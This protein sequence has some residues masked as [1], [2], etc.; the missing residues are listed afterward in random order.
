MRV[1][2]SKNL[3]QAVAALLA[4][5]GLLAYTPALAQTQPEPYRNVDEFGVDVSTGTFN[6]I[7][8]ALSAGGIDYRRFWTRAGWNDQWGGTLTDELVSGVR[9]A[10]I[11]R[12]GISDIFKLVSG[13]WVSQKG[14]GG[15]LTRTT[16]M[17]GQYDYQYRDAGGNQIHFVSLGRQAVAPDD[18]PPEFF[19]TAGDRG[20]C[21]AGERPFS[22][23]A[24]PLVCAVPDAMEMADGSHYSLWWDYE[25]THCNLVSPPGTYS[26]NLDYRLRQVRANN[27][28]SIGYAYESATAGT[29]AWFRKTKV[30]LA[31]RAAAYC[32]E[33]DSCTASGP[34]NIYSQPASNTQQ[35][36]DQNGGTWLFT[37]DINRRITSIQKPGDSTAST[38]ITYNASGKVASVTKDGVAKT[39]TWSTSSGNEVLAISG[40]ASGGATVTTDPSQEQ[41]A[42]IVNAASNTTSNTY[43]ASNRLTRTTEP[44]GNYF[45]YTY[46]ARG[47]NAETRLVA[48]SASGLADIVTTAN[49]DAAC[50]NPLKCNKPNYVIDPLGNRTDYTYSATH[51]QVTRVQLPSP[52]ADAPGTETGTRP[53]IHYSHTALYAKEKN[54][55][56]TLVNVATPEYKPTTI[57]TCA[58][59]ATCA[60]TANETKVTIEYNTPNLLPTK[61][62]TASGNGA[63]SSSVAYTYDARNNL[64]SVDG[65]LAGTDDTTSYIYDAN[66]RRRGVIGPDPDGAGS[67]PRGAE[68]YTFDT[69]SRVIKAEVGTVTAATEAALNAMTVIQTLD[70]T[71]D[72]AGNKTKDVLSGTSGAVSVVQYSY[73][74]LNRLECT[75]LRMNSATWASLPASACTPATASTTYGPDRISRNSYDS[76]GRVSKVE[77]AVGAAVASDEVRTAFTANG[78]VDYVIDAETNRTTY[79]YDGFDR[80]SQTRYPVT[81]KGAN[82]SNASDYEGLTYDARSSVT[83]RRLRDGTS[84]AYSY[85]DLG[86]LTTKDLPGSEPNTTY[87]YDLMGGPTSIDKAGF[88]ISF[89]QDALGRLMSQ[90]GPLGT[91]GYTYDAA[92]RRLTM[93]Y[94]GGTLTINYDYDVVGNV[95][96]IREN[97]ATSGVGV[98]AAYAYDNVGRRSSVTFGN[99]SV[100]SFG[101]DASQRLQTLTNDL[102]GA[103]TTHDLTQIFTYNPASQIA[104]VARSNDAYAWQAH[105][106]LDRAYVADG[107]NRIMSA[108]GTAYT[109]DARGNLSISG[110]S[111]SSENLLT[112]VNGVSGMAY[113]PLGRLFHM[114]STSGWTRFGYDGADMILETDHLSNIRRY[115]HGPGLD[116]PIVWYEGSAINSTTRR[117]LMADERGSVLSVT[118]SGGATMSINAYDEYGIPAPGNIGRFGYTGQAW[119]P[120][121]R[122]WYYKARIYSPTLGRFLQ[123]DPIGY[124]DGMNWY[125]YVGSDPVNFSDPTGLCG[126][127]MMT[128]GPKGDDSTEW[129]K[130]GRK[131]PPTLD[132]ESLYRL[133]F[134]LD[135]VADSGPSGTGDGG[136]GAGSPQK[137]DSKYIICEGRALV[138]AGN[139]RHVGRT[140]GMLRPIRS[141]A[142]AIIPRQ[143]TGSRTAGPLLRSQGALVGGV[144]GGGQI[145]S[146]LDDTAGNT[147]IGPDPQQTLIDRADGGLY[148]ELVT[149]QHEGTSSVTLAIPKDG[150][151]SCPAGTTQTGTH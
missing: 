71:Y 116:N 81:T 49:Y 132:L 136:G 60:G 40:G 33:S 56:G 3:K 19:S 90:T 36:V 96:K 70:T 107:L 130:A 47:N 68:R 82:S 87:V 89:V 110:Y 21:N 12:G 128:A 88:T 57:T 17:P 25:T 97:G 27:G 124:A 42:T 26:C 111:Y 104:S 28:Y 115:V 99:G 51:G 119:L 30:V 29:E 139:P 61:V 46:D 55:S 144:T 32:S 122:M 91:I 43:D 148:I 86:K 52:D 24:P 4:L 20:Y 95:T 44:E 118:D 100:Q 121:I 35:V 22:D 125:N 129:S 62:T 73:D 146:G 114:S 106:N 1:A 7:M 64:A 34:A 38:T 138:Y 92:G 48:K 127:S 5:I 74:S 84:I 109:Y 53:E 14:D 66:D 2:E 15:T 50:T 31:D 112:S 41:P 16:V 8:P 113:D 149:G 18:S 105:Y 9:T 77:S 93:S 59:A 58:T 6:F 39:Y 85:D 78:R 123:T 54:S 63:I 145:F 83:Q 126:L 142:A 11:R 102:G 13:I 140:G 80:L 37:Y 143:W 151:L 141:G 79:I 45:N 10:T 94:P 101:F 133:S 72:T 137:D 131:C 69:A 103:A 150:G 117:F 135:D 120:E 67:R 23:F 76:L 134:W 147:D 108:G 65:P 98:L 75:A